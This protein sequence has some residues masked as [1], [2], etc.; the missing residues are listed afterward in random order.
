LLVLHR[1]THTHTP[2]V[3][4]PV[5]D[6]HTQQIITIIITTTTT[7]TTCSQPRRSSALPWHASSRLASDVTKSPS[8]SPSGNHCLL[9]L[10]GEQDHAQ[11]SL[12]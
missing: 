5:P 11:T 12:A 1:H 9:H 6:T 10:P 3:H 4:R 8:I 7:T 2:L